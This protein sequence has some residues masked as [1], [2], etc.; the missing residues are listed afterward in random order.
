[1]II[2]LTPAGGAMATWKANSVRSSPIPYTGGWSV[3]ASI[4]ESIIILF[5]V[6]FFL[7]EMIQLCKY[8]VYDYFQSA[9]LAKNVH[10]LNIFFYIVVWSYKILAW[11][12]IPNAATN[13]RPD[14]YLE[15]R[16]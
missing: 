3:F 13:V 5:Y 8:G 10:M 1:M 7:E 4:C 6:Y 9:D 14:T 2:Q 12:A 11:S 15:M 16:R